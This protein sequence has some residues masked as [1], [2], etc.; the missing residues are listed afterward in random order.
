MISLKASCPFVTAARSLMLAW[1]VKE[2]DWV[3]RQLYSTRTGPMHGL[4]NRAD[5]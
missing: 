5:A 3:R 1:P 2:A 4:L